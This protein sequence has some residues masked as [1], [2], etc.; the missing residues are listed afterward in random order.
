TLYCCC[1]RAAFGPKV[2]EIVDKIGNTWNSR[3]RPVSMKGGAVER[4]LTTHAGSLIRPPELLEFNAAQARGEAVDE[5]AYAKTLKK[6]VEDAV[7][8]QVDAGVD[9]INDGEMGKS[10][11]ITYLYERMTGLEP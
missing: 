6:T 1:R 10:S 8:R 2:T 3:A 4:I 11:W 5:D 7:K 9:V